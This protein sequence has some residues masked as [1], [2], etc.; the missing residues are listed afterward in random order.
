PR[1]GPNRSARGNAPG[2]DRRPRSLPCQGGTGTPASKPGAGVLCRP[3]RAWGGIP[4]G[5]RALPWADLLRPLRGRNPPHPGPSRSLIFS[6]SREPSRR[7]RRN[8]G[9]NTTP[10]IRP[11]TTKTKSPLTLAR[12][13]LASAQEA[14]PQYS[15]KF[16]RHDFT[17]H[18]LSALL[19][20]RRYFQTD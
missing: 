18:Q 16:S 10:T 4:P 9:M 8:M 15:S 7:L 6:I 3:F 13:A 14:L 5:P 17:Q 1:R 2:T 12:T 19:A 11:R 20:L